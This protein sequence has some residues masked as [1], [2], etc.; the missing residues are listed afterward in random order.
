M[1]KFIDYLNKL[2]ERHRKRIEREIKM[3]EFLKGSKDNCLRINE[4]N[5]GIKTLASTVDDMNSKV[6]NLETAMGNIKEKVHDLNNTVGDMNSKVCGLEKD[7][8]HINGRL[9]IIGRG[10]QMELFDTLYHWRKIL[11]ER[12]YVTPAEKMEIEHIYHVYHDGL[13]GNGQGEK[14]YNDINALEEREATP[15]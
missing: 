11:T 12:G 4:I 5:H 6:N 2:G 10:T 14:Y 8:N 3:D 1:S 7:I 13:G 9:E 15:E